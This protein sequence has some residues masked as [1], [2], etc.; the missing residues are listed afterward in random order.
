MN[1]YPTH[2][3]FQVVLEKNGLRILV[4]VGELTQIKGLPRGSEVRVSMRHN[5]IPIAFV[6]LGR[7][8]TK[9]ELFLNADGDFVLSTAIARNV[10]QTSRVPEMA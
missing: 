1:T 10:R 3:G 4:G 5:T 7:S 8:I 9:H 6:R 2:N